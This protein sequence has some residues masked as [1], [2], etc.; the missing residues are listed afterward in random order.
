MR[1]VTTC[2]PSVTLDSPASEVFGLIRRVAVAFLLLEH[3]G[4]RFSAN[5]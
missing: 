2:H 1:R 5:L 3:I 4:S